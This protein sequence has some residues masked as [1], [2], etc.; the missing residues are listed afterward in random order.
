MH[1]SRGA[2]F[3]YR[4]AVLWPDEEHAVEPVGTTGE[5]SSKG[6]RKYGGLVVCHEGPAYYE[7]EVRKRLQRDVPDE[8]G[9]TPVRNIERVRE[10]NGT[11]MAI[12]GTH[13]L[14]P[15]IGPISRLWIL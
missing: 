11:G 14:L 15:K 6:S 3:G 9:Q 2:P 5:A 12:R 4:L 7:K 1:T 10:R 8:A 13:R